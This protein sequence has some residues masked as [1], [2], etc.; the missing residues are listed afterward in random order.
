MRAAGRGRGAGGEAPVRVTLAGLV[1]ALHGVGWRPD[2]PA[3]PGWEPAAGDGPTDVAVTVARRRRRAAG[4]GAGGAGWPLRGLV[5]AWWIPAPGGAVPGAGGDPTPDALP[6]AGARHAG[7][8]LALRLEARQPL[9]TAVAVKFAL[10][11]T[12]PRRGGLLLHAAAVATAPAGPPAAAAGEGRAGAW[13]LLGGSGAGKTTLATAFAAAGG[14]VL[15]DETVAVLP[16]GDGFVVHATPFWGERA[17]PPGFRLR[18]LPLRGLVWLGTAEG[19]PALLR[20]LLL[21]AAAPA[22][23]AAALAAATRLLAAGPGWRLP[24]RDAI[25]ERCGELQRI[26]AS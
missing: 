3:G 11:L 7:G 20:R 17:P 24:R 1:F 13:L 14:E 26:V 19:L 8:P 9:P 2:V 15:S 25:L 5:D 18:A 16:A 10:A 12:L 4:V 6:V 22:L 23:K 21:P